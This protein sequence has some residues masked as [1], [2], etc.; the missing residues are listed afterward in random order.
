MS[1]GKSEHLGVGR[2]YF[3]DDDESSSC[4][5]CAKLATNLTPL[6]WRQTDGTQGV[7][8][9]CESCRAALEAAQGILD[10]EIEDEDEIITTIALASYVGL[11]WTEV[12]EE[13]PELSGRVHSGLAFSRN[14]DGM[15]L[16]R[17]LPVTIDLERYDGTDLPREIRIRA[18]SRAVRPED[19]ALRYKEVLAR[20]QIPSDECPAGSVAWST[21]N[22][23]L[24]IAVKPGAE[25]HPDRAQHLAMYPPGLIYRF[26]TVSVIKATYEAL[27][28]S[29]DQRT[30]HGHAYAL[31]YHGRPPMN[32]KRRETNVLACLACCFGELDATTRPAERHPRISRALNRHLL[33]RYNIAQLPESWSG[34][35][36]LR[37]NI[38]DVGAQFMRASFLWQEAACPPLS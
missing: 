15:P 32:W 5:L 36:N 25:I 34:N 30:F 12:E 29:V 21:E 14:V 11:A 4:T 2:G 9:A 26:P 20:E 19:V 23:T 10:N 31:G 18:T 7:D 27:L 35:G 8:Y 28:G 3:V 33:S 16:F 6:S 24:T 37:K 1:N 17:M 38:K 22:A 13:P